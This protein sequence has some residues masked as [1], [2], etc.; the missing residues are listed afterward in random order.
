MSLQPLSEDT[1]H[2]DRAVTIF[3]LVVP[4]KSTEGFDDIYQEVIHLDAAPFRARRIVVRLVTCIVVVI[5]AK[6]RLRSRST[7]HEN[8]V[9]FQVV[10]PKARGQLGGV[11]FRQD[12]LIVAA[13][14]AVDE[15]VLEPGYRSAVVLIP[16]E[17]L[18]AHLRRR[19]RIGDLRIPLGAERRRLD[20]SRVR[21]LYDLCRGV[22]LVALRRRELFEDRPKMRE[23]VE[24]EVIETLLATLDKAEVS[25]ASPND[26]TR[27][28]YSRMVRL[29]E[30]RT[31]ADPS[32]RIYVSDL[33]EAAGVSER[34]LQTAFREAVGMPPVSFLKRVRLHQA[35]RALET[36]TRGSTRVT[37]VAL[38]WG[39]WHFGEFS[40]AYKDCFG[41]SPSSTL[42][43][44]WQR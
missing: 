23:A 6:T 38:D 16:P 32:A 7:V 25:E 35:R 24:F 21:S 5:W 13:P 8:L 3:D 42:R 39:F 20:V 10:A 11:A 36:A 26:R 31:L 17:Q 29:A 27:R 34:T 19:G 37:N 12:E 41:E 43:R 2:T 18:L 1:A 44:K 9:A 14:G 28:Q 4:T 15:L 40:R 30:K 22:S 33:C